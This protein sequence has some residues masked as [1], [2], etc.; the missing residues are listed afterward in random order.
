MA[1]V[2]SV[3]CSAAGTST[4]SCDLLYIPIKS[5]KDKMKQKGEDEDAH[6]VVS[7]HPWLPKQFDIPHLAS[8]LLGL[9]HAGIQAGPSAG[10]RLV[11]QISFS[12]PGAFGHPP[13]TGRL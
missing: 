3:L 8:G 6:D 13:Q 2:T 9:W 4:L 12:S 1:L 7:V 10:A 5:K 11:G